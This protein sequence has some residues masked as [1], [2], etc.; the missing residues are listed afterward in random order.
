MQ[1]GFQLQK[2]LALFLRQLLHRDLRPQCDHLR[3]LVFTDHIG[4]LL[5]F[6]LHALHDAVIFLDTLALFLLEFGRLCKGFHP[7]GTLDLQV[8]L[9]DLLRQLLEL[10]RLPGHFQ[11]HCRRRLI[12][13]V[14]GLIRQVPVIDIPGRQ[15][16]SGIDR[17]R[18]D[19]DTVM[20]LI[21]VGN[22]FE[23]ILRLLHG[24][25][26]HRDR[27]ESSLQCRVSLHVFPIFC[28]RGSAD[29]LNLS[30]GQ[31]RFQDIGSV[32]SPF[33]AAGSD[34]RMH[35]IQEKN[36]IPVLDH[37]PDHLLDPFLEF[38]AVL[39]SRHHTGQIQR[40]HPLILY[41]K[42]HLTGHDPGRKP[43]H[44][45]SLAHARLPDQTG[46]VLRPAA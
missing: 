35:F 2:T 36:D 46:I 33:R 13:Q 6:L 22:A 15:R 30:P 39:A 41:R 40:K 42:G 18:R 7:D 8:D 21:F 44:H 32:D 45:C 26:F 28:D 29:Q 19:R 43:F 20:F 31:G 25:F 16:H 14:D 24:R 3:D 10:I 38:T 12:N 37:F 34:D 5:F 1:D 4:A 23:N 11:A 17:L 27:L 9:L